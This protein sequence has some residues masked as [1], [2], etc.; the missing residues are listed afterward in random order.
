MSWRWISIAALLAAV[1]VAYGAFVR[2]DSLGVSIGTP[3]E[4][5]G[6]YL[7][8]AVVT[9]TQADGSLGMRLVT[10]RIEQQAS[11][12]SIVLSRVRIDYYQVPERQ[13]ILSADQ[14]FVPA[15]SRVV[16]LT[17]DVSLRSATNPDESFLRVD[18]LAVDTVRNIAFSTSSPVVIQSGLH[19]MTVQSF[20]A[21]L[22]EEKIRAKAVQGRFT[23]N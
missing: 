16:H 3:P 17:G 13:W 23:A 18:S 1:V 19:R 7:K 6:Y 11:D 14:G 4:Q 15:N 20:E 22:T 9:Q 8:D 5:P 2:R 12:D 21:D 10:S